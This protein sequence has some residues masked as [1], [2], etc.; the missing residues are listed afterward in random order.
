MYY[1]FVSLR[2]FYGISLSK[3]KFLEI[4]AN[5]KDR[6]LQMEFEGFSSVATLFRNHNMVKPLKKVRVSFL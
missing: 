6:D 4:L 5:L 3:F 2:N 1:P